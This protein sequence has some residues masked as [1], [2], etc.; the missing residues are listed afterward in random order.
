[1][2]LICYLFDACD[3]LPLFPKQSVDYLKASDVVDNDTG[4]ATQSEA[5]TSTGTYFGYADDEV[6]DAIE[7]R[8]AEVSRIPKGTFCTF[9]CSTGLVNVYCGLFIHIIMALSSQCIN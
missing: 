8:I 1:M 4:K 6:I 5:R 9:V 3:L 7:K 2:I